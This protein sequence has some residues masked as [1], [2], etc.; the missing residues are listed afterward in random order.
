MRIKVLIIFFLMSSLSTDL[1]GTP[2]LTMELNEVIY[3]TT[4]NRI[5]TVK[6]T[7]AASL[8]ELSYGREGNFSY[9]PEEI[10]SK[11]LDVDIYSTNISSSLGIK[12]SDNWL[13]VNEKYIYIVFSSYVDKGTKKDGAYELKATFLDSNFKSALILDTNNNAIIF[14]HSKLITQKTETTEL[15]GSFNSSKEK[16]DNLS[17]PVNCAIDEIPWDWISNSPITIEEILHRERSVCKSFTSAFNSLLER[18]GKEPENIGVS[19][20]EISSTELEITLF[21][22]EIQKG[23]Q[24]FSFSNSKK[25]W[26]GLSG[27]TGY[28][29]VRD[30]NIID[31]FIASQ[32]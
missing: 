9:L 1:M 24:I 18:D 22:I 7:N 29:L 26:D 12:N 16:Q 13:S 8:S 21:D 14:E 30:N 28:V 19:C 23:D 15:K 11:I 10:L 2:D 17:S 31:Y 5:I 20:P 6:L 25:C 4:E 27:V 3:K 32:S